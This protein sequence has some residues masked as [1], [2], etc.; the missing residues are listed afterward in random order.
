VFCDKGQP[1]AQPTSHGP[2]VTRM[3]GTST[4]MVSHRIQALKLP[5]VYLQQNTS[6]SS[7]VY[8]QQNNIIFLEFIFSSIK[9]KAKAIFL[10]PFSFFEH[11]SYRSSYYWNACGDIYAM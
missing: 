1:V 5:Q 11:N 7:Q 3:S 10:S 9:K 2:F 8:L 4:E 6:S